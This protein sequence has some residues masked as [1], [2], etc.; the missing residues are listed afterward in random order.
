MTASSS[1]N[2]ENL[3]F[4]AVRDPAQ[5]DRASGMWLERFIFNNRLAVLLVSLVATL[6]LGWQALQLPVNASFEKMIPSSHPYIQNFFRHKEALRGLGNS[7]R[8]VVEHTQGDIFDKG[9]LQALQKVNDTVYLV[10][11]VDRSFMRGLWTTSLRWTE[12]TE[13]GYRGGP[14]MPDNF[15]ASPA[16]MDQL[17]AN[18][19][20]AGIVG[21]YVA[22]NLR[23][24]MIVVPLLDTNPE[25]RQPLDYATFSADLERKVRALQNDKVKIHIVG[26]AKIVGDLIEGLGQVISFFGLSALIAGLFVYAFTR[27]IRST[28][29]LVV[30]SAL[31]VV[32]LLGLMHLLGYVLDPYSILVPFLIFAI[33]LSHGA[34]KMNGV[35]QDVARGTHKYVAARYTFRRLFLAGLTALL[36][37]VVGFAVLMV[38]DIPAIRDLALITSVGVSVLIFTK[39]VLIPV[40]L[41]YVGVSPGAAARSVRAEQQTGERGLVARLWSGLLHFTE[42]RWALPAAGVSLVLGLA[43]FAVSFQLKIGDLDPGAPELRPD[44]RYNRD[45]A[46]VNAN[47]GLSSDPFVVMVQ[48]PP[49]GCKQ[50]A[51]LVEADRLGAALRQVDGV[52]ATASSSD[53]VRYFTAGQFEGNPKWLAIPRNAS[54]LNTA[55]DQVIVDRPELAEPRC[56]VTPLIAYLSDHKAD[57]LARVVSAVEAFG[58]DHG[59]PDRQFLLAAGSA[60][61][62]A[63]TNIVVREATRGMLLRLYAA[64][65]LLC[66]ITFR[67]WR[68]VVVALVPLL[69]TSALCEALMVA[70]GIGV[71]VATL[72]VI[73]LGVG[74]GVDYALYLLSVQLALQRRGVP[75]REAYMRSLRFTGRVVALVGLTMAAGVV[76]WAFSP[77]KFQADMGILLTFMFL[78]NMIGALVLIPALSHLLLRGLGQHSAAPPLPVVDAAPVR[79]ASAAEAVN[80]E[81]VQRQAL[82]NQP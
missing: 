46:F 28:A 36:T 35:M 80:T 2:D 53:M 49:D 39:L 32:W 54:M 74:V 40:L 76:T 29:L 11:G 18:I 78:W 50:F 59:T 82:A 15:D 44:S 62:E 81:P 10:P 4:P 52:K 75:L 3:A 14:V 1:M 12:V 17:K 67:S 9:Y 31:G 66:F 8:I 60:G 42:R 16:M 65:V 24:T 69:I 5:F 34:Q 72:P 61:I 79:V 58:R 33:G 21:S 51:T 63:A 77:I 37:N 38:I 20:R 48:T 13:E 26:F 27:D 47:Y 64:V 25:T 45:V 73:A 30:V 23:S 19:A 71:K 70:L 43:A 22:G 55:V 57:T 56:A 41:S 7:V 68:A 6:V